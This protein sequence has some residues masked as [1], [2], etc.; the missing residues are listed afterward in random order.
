MAEHT[1]RA[2]RTRSWTTTLS[3]TGGPAA[4][5]E[6]LEPRCNLHVAPARVHVPYAL[7]R[8][9][10]AD[11]GEARARERGES[12]REPLERLRRAGEQ[13]LVVLA[14]S[15]GPPEHVGAE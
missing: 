1:M 4:R 8:S 12:V 5:R 15:G 3:G 11:G 9:D 2:A 10:G 14:A 6:V 7:R 13:Q